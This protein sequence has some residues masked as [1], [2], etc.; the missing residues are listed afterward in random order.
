VEGGHAVPPEKIRTRHARL[1]PLIAQGVGKAD[2]PNCS[3]TVTPAASV[4]AASAA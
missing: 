1:L 2:A 4:I 3:I